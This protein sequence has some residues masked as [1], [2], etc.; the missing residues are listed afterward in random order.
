MIPSMS[1]AVIVASSRT[2]LA[3]YGRGSFNL[4]RP[5]DLAAHAIG[6]QVGAAMLGAAALPSVCGLIAQHAGL[7]LVPPT[8]LGSVLI[9]LA[10]TLGFA[11][12]LLA[13]HVALETAWRIAFV[14][15]FFS[16]L[17]LPRDPAVVSKGDFRGDFQMHSTWS[18]GGERIEA[19]AEG[20]LALGHTCMGITDHSYGL[21][22]ARGISMEDARRQH[23]EKEPEPAGEQDDNAEG[24]ENLVAN[25]HHK[26]PATPSGTISP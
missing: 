7:H 4:T 14:F 3:K 16:S 13:W 11:L 12:A 10:V 5:D 24:A 18:E 25:R 1:E 8:L 23:R 21:P 9:V 19:M 6:F 17:A 26:S 2:P 20:C 22:I 15:L